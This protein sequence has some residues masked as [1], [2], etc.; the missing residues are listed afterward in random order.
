MALQIFPL[1]TISLIIYTV[2]TVTGMGAEAGR[3]WHDIIV[4]S[5]PMYS[6]DIWRVTW[7]TLFLAGSMGLLFVELIRATKA[8]TASI[9]NHLLSFLLFVVALLLFILAPGFGNSVYFIFLAM[10]F[11]DPMAGLVVTTVTAR[12]DLA[13]TPAPGS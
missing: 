2:L 5:L 12:R 4:I 10:T 6:G 1:L 8:G 13:V 9:T 7:G 3:D 11:L